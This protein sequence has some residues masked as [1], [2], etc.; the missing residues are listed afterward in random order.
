MKALRVVVGSLNIGGTEQHLSVVLPLLAT[1]GWKI[2]IV[3]LH[4]PK[5][6]NLLPIFEVAG[7]PVLIPKKGASKISRIFF[8]IWNLWCE[9]RRDPKTMTHFFLPE[10]YLLGMIMAF[11]ART[12]ACLMMSRRSLNY[13]Q[14]KNYF[15]KK[16][17]WFLHRKVNF[18]LGNSQAI[19]DQ[20][21]QEEKVPAQKLRLIH[22]GVDTQKYSPA[23]SREMIRQSLNIAQAEWVF[24]II[25]NLIPYKGHEDLLRAFGEIRE[26]IKGSWRLLCV[27]RDDGILPALKKL[28]ENLQIHE[29][30]Q[31]LG[32]RKEV[33]QLLTAADVGILC[34]HEE[35]FSN[36]ILEAMSCGLPMVVTR[37]G[38][39]AEAV[40]EGETG[41]IV[42]AK[43]PSALGEALLATMDSKSKK[44]GEAARVRVQQYFSIESCVAAYE[45]FYQSI[46]AEKEALLCAD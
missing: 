25:A 42:P 34:S 30:V 23:V 8:S 9:F 44:M 2:K 29:Q 4:A 20:L 27:G 45:K 10:A 12:K 28:A 26:K 41:F 17:E 22:N 1:R 31:W 15:L 7:I 21:Q 38:G 16:L 37:V 3:L 5:E 40:V 43:N 33:P 14:R 39:N 6:P 35:G 24:I 11:L 19:V 18:I 13:Y 46:E 32:T 36:A